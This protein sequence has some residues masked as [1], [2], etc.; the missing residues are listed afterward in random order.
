MSGKGGGRQSWKDLEKVLQKV[1]LNWC[2]SDSLKLSLDGR[3][4]ARS[5]QMKT[6]QSFIS[7]QSSLVKWMLWLMKDML[8]CLSKSLWAK[9][10]EA[11][12]NT[13]N[14]LVWPWAASTVPKCL[15]L[16][17]W[18][19]SSFTSYLICNMPV[20]SQ[21]T[22]IFSAPSSHMAQLLQLWVRYK[23]YR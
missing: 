14:T 15:Y 1:T 23:A 22:G 6:V 17:T 3:E 7:P 18:P 5:E 9:N 8:N 4:E 2:K 12:E 20:F 21:K 10:T 19:S 16:D 11:E 13:W